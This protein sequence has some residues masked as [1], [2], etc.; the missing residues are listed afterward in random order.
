MITLDE[1]VREFQLAIIGEVRSSTICWYRSHLAS[2][3][4]A[5]G[6]ID[7]A[8]ITLRD[9]REWRAVEFSR[10]RSYTQHPQRPACRGGLSDATKH[11]KIRAVKRLFAWLESER[12]VNVNPAARLKLPRRGRRAPKA[13]SDADLVKLQDAA[14]N[15]R[16]LAIVQVLADTGARVGGLA[17][18]RLEDVD[19]REMTLVVTEKGDRSREVYLTVA[20]APALAEWI[21]EHP[22][23]TDSVF[24]SFT[25]GEGLTTG[26]IAQMLKRLSV[27]AGTAG[28]TNPHSFRHGFARALLKN[29]LSLE[30]VSELMGHSDVRVTAEAYA[31]WTREELREKHS[32]FSR[33]K[34]L[35]GERE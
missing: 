12:Y 13:V 10:K 18:L 8:A 15:S 26:G 28:R 19:L 21:E 11:G 5:L 34:N 17:G 32:K 2:L 14:T 35:H 3:V 1:A 27:R 23:S 29:G 4:A 25:S 30:S 16:D 6:D 22:G 24:V 31:V 33:L 9:L 7:V 20:S